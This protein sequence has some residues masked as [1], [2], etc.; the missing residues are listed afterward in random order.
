MLSSWRMYEMHLA[1]FLKVGCDRRRG[2]FGDCH[3]WIKILVLLRC[4]LVTAWWTPFPRSMLKVVM[5]LRLLVVCLMRMK[6]KKKNK[7]R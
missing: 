5:M 7:F 3:A 2:D 4:S 6:R 1:L